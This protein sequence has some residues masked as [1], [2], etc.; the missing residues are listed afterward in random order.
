LTLD[1]YAERRDVEIEYTTRGWRITLDRDYAVQAHRVDIQHVDMQRTD[2]QRLVLDIDGVAKSVWCNLEAPV[3]HIRV[4]GRQASV[5]ILDPREPVDVQEGSEGGLRSPMPGRVVFV[6]VKAGDR[7]Q[8]GAALLA[9]EAMK[10]E[11][12]ICAPADGIVQAV[13][14]TAGAQVA[15]AVALVDFLAE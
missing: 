13:H 8:R 14:V 3:V 2:M 6:N 12:V 15:E 5:R 11:H 1:A 7:V 10:M 9:I 4:D